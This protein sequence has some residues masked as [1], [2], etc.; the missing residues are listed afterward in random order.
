[1]IVLDTNVISELMRPSPHPAVLGW[2]AAQPRATVY[3]TSVNQ[4]EILYGIEALSVGRRRRA[5]AD[6]AAALFGDD[7]AGRV[8]SFGADAASHYA[9]IV[10]IRRKSG[11]PIEAFDALIAATARAAGAGVATR[12]IRGFDECGLAV[13]DP[14]QHS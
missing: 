1:M 13:I 7:F 14:W 3:T 5:L 11:N 2:I 6:A 8:L 4:A 9:A 12:D 10:A